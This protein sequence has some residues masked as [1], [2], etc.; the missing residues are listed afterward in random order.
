[1]FTRNCN[2]NPREKY[3]KIVFL[4]LITLGLTACGGV[5]VTRNDTNRAQFAAKPTDEEAIHKIRGYLE[6]VLIDPDSLRLKCSKVTDRAWARGNV[7]DE[8]QFGY[9]V[10]CDVNAKNK[11]GGYT[12]GTEYIFLFNGSK[13]QA[14][15][16]ES[17]A[18]RGKYYNLVQ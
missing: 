14:F 8:P 15:D 3:M 6:N 1:M 18:E 4:I 17:G 11:M 13:F 2:N 9:L 16:F 5:Q 7:Y 10:V 12:G